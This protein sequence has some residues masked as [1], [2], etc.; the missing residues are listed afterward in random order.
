MVPL[1][2]L[3]IPILLSAVVVFVASSVIHMV[4]RYHQNDFKRI[5]AEDD[6][7]LALRPFNMVLSRLPWKMSGALRT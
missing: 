7:M 1:M 4:L 6:V 5:P 2:S 3:S